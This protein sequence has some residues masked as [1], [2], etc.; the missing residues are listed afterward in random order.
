MGLSGWGV[1]IQ[2]FVVLQ[3]SWAMYLKIIFAAMEYKLK[4]FPESVHGF[5]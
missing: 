5:F 3:N 1:S 2:I 4:S